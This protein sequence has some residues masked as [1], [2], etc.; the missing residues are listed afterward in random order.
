MKKKLLSLMAVII[1]LMG[2]QMATAQQTPEYKTWWHKNVAKYTEGGME[3]TVPVYYR[4]TEYDNV[5]RGR[6]EGAV[7]QVYFKSMPV[8]P[9][10]VAILLEFPH[11]R[12]EIFPTIADADAGANKNYHTIT[13]IGQLNGEGQTVKLPKENFPAL[14]EMVIGEKIEQ[15]VANLEDNY[16]T[17]F[18]QALTVKSTNLKEIPALMC[19]NCSKLKKLTF[20]PGCKVGAI[21]NNAFANTGL[22][23]VEIPT[24]IPV[25]AGYAFQ[26]NHQLTRV[27][28]KDRDNSEGPVAQKIGNYAFAFSEKITSVVFEHGVKEIAGSAFVSSPINQRI[29]FPEGLEVIGTLAFHAA[30][31]KGD[32]ILPSSLKRIEYG[33]FGENPGAPGWVF[34][35]GI[36][37]PDHIEV[38]GGYAFVGSRKAQNDIVIPNTVKEIGNFCFG[39]APLTGTLTIPSSVTTIGNS[40]FGF[41]GGLDYVKFQENN[42]LTLGDKVFTGCN[43]LRYIDMTKVNSAS[44]LAG[45]ATKKMD[46]NA[47]AFQNLP[48]YTLVY[49]PQNFAYANKADFMAD[50]Q[51]NFIMKDD[52]GYRCDDFKVYD[53]DTKY[54]SL[55]LYHLTKTQMK[56]NP[57]TAAELDALEKKYPYSV[58]GCDYEIP[59]AFTA[60]KAAYERKFTANTLN[61]F[62]VSL[63]YGGASLAPG[64]KAYKL[65]KE[66]DMAGSL[67][68]KG[69]WFVSLDDNRL[70][71]KTANEAAGKLESNHPYVLRFTDAGLLTT[72]KFEAT[73][74][75]VKSTKVGDDPAD[76]SQWKFINTNVNV[77]NGD[78][79]AQKLYMLNGST[80]T[81]HAVRTDNPN[82]FFH[83][84][85]GAMQYM[86]SGAAK[87]FPKFIEPGETTGIESADI[88]PAEAKTVVYTVD[89]RRVEGSLDNAA[90]GIYVVNGK[91][92][93]K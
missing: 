35:N 18:I 14:Y 24:N 53:N 47:N 25:I 22:E 84:F 39:A 20:A 34:Y 27:V 92:V 90:S 93:V 8:L 71:N 54:Q 64:V 55:N 78:A 65:V 60:D 57:T 85:R 72:H 21:G 82:G 23:E 12:Q 58:R 62:S 29:D 75:E 66:M 83:S 7:T 40:A 16:S 74:V 81:W 37:L 9:E 43:G 11:D 15:M 49:L 3:K 41:C 70:V 38:L 36:Q 6:K 50:N 33:V 59:Y 73:G 61:I 56:E 13:R 48:N 10:G 68:E 17:G 77:Y 31:I 69:L 4:I 46:R 67:N 51:V 26:K 42:V 32:L 2:S 89:G 28:F 79:A 88:V 30:K 80:K 76:G 91:K 86:G 52:A 63:P 87:D 5:D 19:Q 44:L 1:M 45:A